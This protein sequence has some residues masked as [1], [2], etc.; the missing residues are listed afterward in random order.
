MNS[1]GA[2]RDDHGLIEHHAQRARIGLVPKTGA[3]QRYPAPNTGPRPESSRHAQGPRRSAAA[4]C[5]TAPV[6]QG[7]ERRRRRMPV[8]LDTRARPACVIDLRV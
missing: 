4:A 8:Q 6:W 2:S 7:P 1:I 3:V 5:V